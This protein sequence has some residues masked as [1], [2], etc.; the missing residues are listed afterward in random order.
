MAL[1]EELSYLWSGLGLQLLWRVSELLFISF[2][3][4]LIAKKEEDE[5]DMEDLQRWAEAV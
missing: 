3:P 1:L 5:D 2:H 4:L